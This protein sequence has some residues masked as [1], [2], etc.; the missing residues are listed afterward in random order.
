[1][2]TQAQIIELL[3]N[4]LPY[5]NQIKDIDII[6]EEDAVRFTW[7]SSKYRV[8]NALCTEQ[9]YNECLITSDTAILI[10]RCLDQS[11]VLRAVSA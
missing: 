4:A 9:A 5:P 8:S 11:V 10:R 2:Y 3:I 1:M 6:S 7:R